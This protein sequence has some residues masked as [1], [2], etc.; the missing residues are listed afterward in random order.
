MQ[1]ALRNFVKS[2][3]SKLVLDL[4]GNPGGYLESSVSIASYFLPLGKVI[5]REN[6]GEGSPEHLYRSSGKELGKSAPKKM[7]VLV[8]G[9]S[10]S[11]SEILAGALREHNVATLIGGTT[12]GKGS[13]QELIDLGD[14]S[15]VKVTIAR[16][17]TP[18]GNS[19]SNGGLAPDIE[20]IRTQEDRTN[21]TDP[22]LEAA[23]EFLNK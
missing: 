13:V 18:N 16:W 4:R 19:I 11:A 7:V 21:N 1:S 6:F 17:L 2:G 10:A 9:G 12:F 22:Q 8:D 20:V 14:G 3:K 23:I 15:S 5:V